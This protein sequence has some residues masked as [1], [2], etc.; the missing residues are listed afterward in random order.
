LTNA[1]SPLPVFLARAKHDLAA[2]GFAARR[3]LAFIEQLFRGG[4][5]F[6]ASTFDPH[7]R[8]SA[9]YICGKRLNSKLF[10]TLQLLG[11]RQAPVLV[12]LNRGPRMYLIGPTPCRGRN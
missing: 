3:L 9:N 7:I 1:I 6:R 4:S 10:E 2:R 12:R 5:L 8:I 11:V